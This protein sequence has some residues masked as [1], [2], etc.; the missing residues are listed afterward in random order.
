MLF[1]VIALFFSRIR[2][3]RLQNLQ[4]NFDCF[5]GPWLFFTFENNGLYVGLQ[6]TL[7]ALYKLVNSV[8]Y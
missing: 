6:L 8:N 4:D 7:R 5:L 1:V 2:F 3:G